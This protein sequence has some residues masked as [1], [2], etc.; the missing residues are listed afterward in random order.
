MAWMWRYLD[1]A[2]EPAEGPGEVFGSQSDAE[3]WLGQC[4]RE[5]SEQ[6]VVTVRLVED[7]RLEYEMSLRPTTAS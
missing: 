3:S 6:G 1:Q 5:L 2:G 7:D 4:W